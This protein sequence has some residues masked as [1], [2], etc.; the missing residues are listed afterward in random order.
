MIPHTRDSSLHLSSCRRHP[1]FT[2]GW[3]LIGSVVSEKLEKSPLTRKTWQN[4]NTRALLDSWRW[5]LLTYRRP[6]LNWQH[7]MPCSNLLPL[8][9]SPLHT[10]TP[11]RQH[12]SLPLHTFLSLSIRDSQVASYRL[13]LPGPS[14]YT[15]TPCTHGMNLSVSLPHSGLHWLGRQARRPVPTPPCLPYH[16]CAACLRKRPIHCRCSPLCPILAAWERQHSPSSILPLKKVCIN[17]FPTG[18]FT[19]VALGTKLPWQTVLELPFF[20]HTPNLCLN[21][22][23]LHPFHKHW[24][25]EGSHLCGSWICLYSYLFCLY[26]WF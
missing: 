13:S 18:W 11:P 21:L 3:S 4:G 24:N 14:T 19:F 20:T 25:R 7:N 10:H 22:K 23:D 26:S 5:I 17:W 12:V 2:F 16:S 1:V 8:Y 6:L 9:M 15:H